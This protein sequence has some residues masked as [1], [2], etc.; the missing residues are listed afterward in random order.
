MGRLQEVIFYLAVGLIVG[1][2]LGYILFYQ[3][4]NLSDYLVPDRKPGNSWAAALAGDHFR[5]K[6]LF[7]IREN[8]NE[9]RKN[10]LQV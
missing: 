1:A 10:R 7:Q 5:G 4:P 2:R 3:F 6:H 9:N 8:Y